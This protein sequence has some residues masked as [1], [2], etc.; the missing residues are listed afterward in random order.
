MCRFGTFVSLYPLGNLSA[1]FGGGEIADRF[2]YPGV[3]EYF[4][5][6]PGHAIPVSEN[7]YCPCPDPC[8]LSSENVSV[9]TP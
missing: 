6:S 2:V 4:F 5:A 3:G 8:S 1:Q 7:V 9:C